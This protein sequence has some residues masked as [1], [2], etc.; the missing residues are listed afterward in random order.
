MYVARPLQGRVDVFD[1]HTSE[2]VNEFPAPRGVTRISIDDRGKRL[3]AAAY[4]TGHVYIVDLT[5][6]TE[7]LVMNLN[8]QITDLAY[9]TESDLVFY[10]T[11]CSIK[12]FDPARFTP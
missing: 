7:P 4:A 6:N 2:R 10:A 9:C 1:L 5:G 12:Y 3:F 8:A 11:R